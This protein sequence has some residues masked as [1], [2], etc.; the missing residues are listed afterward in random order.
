[1]ASDLKSVQMA[2]TES[3]RKRKQAETQL[4]EIS[5]RYQE[6]ERGKGET[7]ERASKLQ[8]EL[9]QA[10]IQLEQ[11]DTKSL[12]LSQRVSS[13]EAQL[14]DTQDICQEETRQKLSLQS[15]LR[16]ADEERDAAVEKQEEAEEAKHVLEKQVAELS[17]KVSISFIYY[18]CYE[19]EK[20]IR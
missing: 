4:A 8:A 19:R 10:C 14:A 2:K 15:K 6:Q 17:Q 20:K 9:E 1:M 13:L 5:V 3:E 16:Q 7:V 12:Q 18:N 11:L